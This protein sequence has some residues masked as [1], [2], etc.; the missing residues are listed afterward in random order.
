[1]LPLRPG[2]IAILMSILGSGTVGPASVALGAGPGPRAG[3]AAISPEE[4][5]FFERQVR[6]LLI[7]HCYECHSTEAKVLKGGLRLDSRGGVM[8]GGDTGPAIVPGAPDDSL[9]IEAIRGESPEMPPKGKL[10]DSEIAVLE[11]WVAM[12]APDPRT[13]A[14]SAEPARPALDAGRAHWAFQPIAAPPVPPVKDAAWPRSDIDRFVLAKLESEGL[15]PV[16]DADR[17]TL[18][19]R[20]FFDLVG[21]PPAPADVASF[22]ADDAPDA[23]EKV[24]DALLTRPEF[25][26]R[27]GRHWLDVARYAD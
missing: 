26:E 22:L 18:L 1:M 13:E 17:P 5:Q 14:A 20:V 21:V 16:A 27:W 24:V 23:L 6:P 8:K 15:R 2:I 3:E 9:L 4:R 19:R 7:K 10:A 12:G 25:G 11:R